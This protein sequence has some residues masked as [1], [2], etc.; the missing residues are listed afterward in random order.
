MAAPK[1]RYSW[2]A[3][4]PMQQK[5]LV[6]IGTLVLLFVICG[7]VSLQSLARQDTSAQWSRHT[8]DVRA[9]L[10]DVIEH[11]QASQMALRG[12]LLNP[13]GPELAAHQQANAALAADLEKLRSLTN[14]NPLQQTRIDRIE[15]MAGQWQKD[16][17]QNGIEPMQAIHASD[18]G[19]A[20]MERARVQT[21]YL[22]RRTIF[23][24]DILGVLKEMDN[25]EAGLLDE[26][27]ATQERDVREVR[28]ITWI[29]MM[30]SLLLGGSVVYM[31][32]R[33]VTRPIR[34]MTDLMT[35]LAEHDHTVE[36]RQLERRDEIGEIARAAGVQADVHRN[37][38]ADLGEDAGLADRQR[39]AESGN[40]ARVRR[41][42]HRH[43]GP[44]A[45]MRRGRV[46][47]F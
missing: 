40:R 22:A 6:A 36:I 24:A 39:P 46:L 12:Y 20:A 29:T 44:A 8:Y 45:R 47:P 38:G 41:A 13:E 14:D 23:V 17:L 18:A 27:K 31:T 5:I 42:A 1:T 9:R 16:A 25:T 33:L 7:V 35:R 11:L 10:D 19:E 15:S 2:L 3:H 37:R 34:R 21:S 4:Q 26:R 30:L 28:A 43:A 32:F